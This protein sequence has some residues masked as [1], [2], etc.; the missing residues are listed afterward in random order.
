MSIST[1]YCQL[2]TKARLFFNACLF[3]C[4]TQSIYGRNLAGRSVLNKISIIKVKKCIQLVVL[5]FTI[6]CKYLE[7]LVLN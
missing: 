4:K 1:G 3:Y 2:S 5:Y 6:A 7:Q